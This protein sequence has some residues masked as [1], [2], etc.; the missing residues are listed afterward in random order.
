MED[1]SMNWDRWVGNFTDEPVFYIKHLVH[2][3]GCRIDLHKMVLPDEEDCFHT[4]P[5]W[6]IRIILKGGYVE[7]INHRDKEE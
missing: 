5:A 4:H 7:E 3:F 1:Y 2:L 6:A